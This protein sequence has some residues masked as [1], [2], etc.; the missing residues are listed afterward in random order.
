MNRVLYV[1]VI[2]GAAGDMLLAAMLDAGSPLESVQAAIDAVFE[3]RYRI[4]TQ[5]VRR[6]G[7]AA[8][9]LKIEPEP[10][11]TADHSLSDL[12]GRLDRAPLEH[13]VARAARSIL[14]RLAK[15]EARVHAL[16][17]EDVALHAVRGRSTTTP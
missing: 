11:A 5:T 9:L 4:G 10:E 13:R 16:G 17:E 1:D 15:A 3:G 7:F 12:A 2:G 8:K 14:G 6:G